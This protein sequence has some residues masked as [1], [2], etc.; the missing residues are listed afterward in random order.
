MGIDLSG[1]TGGDKRSRFNTAYDSLCRRRDMVKIAP[2]NGETIYSVPRDYFSPA[3]KLAKML[4]AGHPDK[5]GRK[6]VQ[7]DRDSL[8][9]IVDWLDL[10]AQF[11]GDYSFN[12]IENQPPLAAGEKALRQAIEKRF[13]AELAR[14]PYATLVNVANIAESRILMASLPRDAG[15]WGQIT[16]NAYK[17]A[18]DPA[19]RQMRE[20]AEASVTPL[21]HHDIH[22]TCGRGDKKGCRCG[23]CWVHEDIEARKKAPSPPATATRP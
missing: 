3:G 14:Q 2:R 6:R 4:L 20:L 11:Y 7:L 19:W 15:G 10:N 21:Q 1:M 5:D 12:R 8:Q 9:R 13:G 22:S 17:G 16:T 18:D 23:N